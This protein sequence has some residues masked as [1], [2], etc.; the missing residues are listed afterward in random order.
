MARITPNTND[1]LMVMAAHR[2]C[3]GRSSYIVSSC[4]EWLDRH[5]DQISDNTKQVVLRDTQSAV[6]E[7]LAGHD[8]DRRAW[9]AFLSRHEKVS[10]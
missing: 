7:N 6:S 9:Q 1:Q 3:L 8:F 5:W 10:L 4:I 2:Y